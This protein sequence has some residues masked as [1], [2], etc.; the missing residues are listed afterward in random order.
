ML[1]R[2]DNGQRLLEI[3]NWTR[4]VQKALR[5]REFELVDEG[6]FEDAVAL[7]KLSVGIQDMA[8]GT[9]KIVADG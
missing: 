2:M 8:I 9:L 1:K 7:G 4:T 6:R 5:R 3:G